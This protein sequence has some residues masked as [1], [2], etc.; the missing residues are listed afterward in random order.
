[1]AAALLAA[2][3]AHAQALKKITL[4]GQ[5][6]VNNDAIWMALEHGYFKQEGLEVDYRVFPSG[7]TAFQT[8][9]TGQGDIVMTGDLPSVQYFFNN[10]GQYQTIAAIERDAKSYVVIARKDIRKPQ[11]LVGKTVATRVGSTGSWFVSEYLAKNG[12]DP[13]SVPVKNLDTQLL[14]AALCK[15]D[16]SAFFIWQPI[17]SRTLE[18]CANDAHQLADATG[19]IQGYLVAGA[20][21][22]FLNSADGADRVVRFLRAIMKGRQ[23]AESDFRAVAA[24]AAKTYSLSEKATRDQWE[25]NIRPIALDKVYYQDF[26]SLSKWARGAGLTSQPVDFTKLTWPNGLRAIDPKLAEAPPPPC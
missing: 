9:R 4:F 8:F 24:F 19:Y 3:T 2:G 12:V 5:P 1:M 6:S 25:T 11:D 13:K 22:E 18:I 21:P 7:T 16:I 10:P 15:G 20:R 23:K 17:G 14:P 26:C